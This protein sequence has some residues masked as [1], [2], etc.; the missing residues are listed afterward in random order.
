MRTTE[1]NRILDTMA[2]FEAQQ[3][4]RDPRY[5]NE[6]LHGPEAGWAGWH[7]QR[8]FTDSGRYTETYRETMNA[9]RRLRRSGA[10]ESH[11]VAS[12]NIT[13]IRLPR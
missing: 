13:L 6:M 10:I 3:I 1:E 8:L 11:H 7:R 12:R 5:A 9:L 4:E 2:K